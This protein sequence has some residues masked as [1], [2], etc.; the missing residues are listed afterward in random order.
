MVEVK[1]SPP[2]QRGNEEVSEMQIRPKMKSVGV[3]VPNRGC[4]RLN[5]EG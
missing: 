3:I 2:Q 5:F 4:S 1:T